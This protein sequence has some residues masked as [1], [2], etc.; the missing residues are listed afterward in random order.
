M[1]ICGRDY[2]DGKYIDFSN[3]K[4]KVWLLHYKCNNHTISYYNIKSVLILDVELVNC[5]YIIF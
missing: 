1:F 3:S 5:N 2:K 4:K